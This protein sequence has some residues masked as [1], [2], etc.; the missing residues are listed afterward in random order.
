MRAANVFLNVPFDDDY[1]PLYVALISAL[2]AFGTTPRTVLEIPPQAARLE[3]LRALIADCSA[4]VHDLSRVEISGKPPVPRF[5]MPFELGL[6]VGLHPNSHK[7]FLFESVPHRVSR[8]LS[9]LGGYDE[10][11]HHGKPEGILRAVTNAFGAK[12]RV[13]HDDLVALWKALRDVVPRIQRERGSLFT[14]A[15]FVDLVLAGQSLRF[16][17]ER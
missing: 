14:H 1:E 13:R 7:W 9:D 15:A 10:M 11:I 2:T 5:N 3:R 6:S 16:E 4:S 17:R 12:K 8:S